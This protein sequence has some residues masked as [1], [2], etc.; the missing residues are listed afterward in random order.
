M[1]PQR[2]G[3]RMVGGWRTK[4]ETEGW[5]GGGGWGTHSMKVDSDPPLLGFN[6]LRNWYV[7]NRRSNFWILF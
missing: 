1:I 6:H 5:G 7:F 2:W 4:S 3:N